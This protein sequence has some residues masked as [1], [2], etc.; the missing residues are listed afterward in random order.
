MNNR[1]INE[2]IGLITIMAITFL[3]N[4]DAY[5]ENMESGNPESKGESG[6][7][8][9]RSELAEKYKW[10]LNDIYESEAMWEQS[11]SEIE[12]ML[13]KIK[14]YEGKL[15]SSAEN[16]LAYF[17][18][19]EEI[20]TKFEKLRMYASLSKDLDLRDSKYQEMY[21]RAMNLGN[22]LA[23]ES[24]FTAP[25]ILDIPEDE[26]WGFLKTNTA[27]KHYKHYLDNII[28]RKSHILDK[29]QEKIMS[30]ASPVEASF[31]NTYRMFTGAD[32]K[33]PI[34]KDESGDDIQMSP[35]RYYSAMTSTDRDYRERAYKA[36]Y[37]PFVNNIN[38][39]TAN[40]NGSI[41][42]KIFRSKSRNYSAT[43]EAALDVNNIPP[44]IYTNL[45]I[46]VIENLEPLQRWGKMK[47]QLLGLDELH[48]YD[49]YVNI[50]SSVQKK[51][52]PDEGMQ[53][54]LEALK[55]LGEDYIKNLRY[56]FENRWVDFHE[57]EGK[58]N[59]AYST[60]AVKGIHP[61][62]L[63]NWG[64]TLNDVFTLAHEMGHNMH[65]WYTINNQEYPYADYPTFLAEVASTT[66]EALLLHYLIEN[67]GS[68]EEKLTLIETA[69]NNI[70]GT[71]YRQT[72]F[73][74]FEMEVQGRIENGEALTSEKYAEIF[75]EMYQ[76]YWGDEMV[77]DEEE[78]NS[79][80]RIHHFY[81]D[82]YVYQYATSFSAAQAIASNMQKEGQ[83]AIDKYLDFLKSGDTD[84]A[85]PTLLKAG[86]DMNT[87]EPF[88]SVIDIANDLLNKLE[89]LSK[90]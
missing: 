86:V 82:F 31:M 32:I 8:P 12:N 70:K 83:T 56:A 57:T 30:Y 61:Y 52:S 45:I 42:A 17:K 3:S 20:S 18:L 11:Y 62:V 2:L 7:L 81:Y 44:I 16:L 55:P 47:K 75:G 89:E 69:L 59:G 28:R 27:L 50:F 51:Y 53:L 38:F 6:K 63:M 33:Y 49:T 66:N 13:P 73:A 22:K 15:G 48:P 14:S 68:K 79:W 5:S 1:R 36:I 10:N 41:K 76:R 64:Y 23:S 67:S 60:G 80:P 87:L 65:S 39:L 37:I 90:E 84:Y 21:E 71:F 46:A 58:R 78:K 72:R 77:V 24:S 4:S 34:I 25:E 29:E 43:L 40:Y 88:L 26:L 35:A 54:C 19:E 74:E 9:L 85:I